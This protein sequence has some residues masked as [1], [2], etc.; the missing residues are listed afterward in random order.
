MTTTAPEVLT[1]PNDGVPLACSRLVEVREGGKRTEG[2][3]PNPATDDVTVSVD[4]RRYSVPMCS[5]HK[6]EHDDRMRARRLRGTP[7][8]RMENRP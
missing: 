4:R 2:L 3:C 1:D 6:A 5:G 8:A 7:A